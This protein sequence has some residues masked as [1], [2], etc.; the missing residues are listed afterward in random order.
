MRVRIAV[1]ALWGLLLGGQG[2]LAQHQDGVFSDYDSLV[3]TM[4]E[5][6]KERRISDLMLAF[7]GSDEMTEVELQQLEARVRSIFPQ[8][9]VHRER[10]RVQMLENN[11]RQELWAFY[12][13]SGYLYTYLV[14][15]DRKDRT[16][17]LSFKF[18]TDFNT[19]NG[20]F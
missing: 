14:I 1:L 20:L 15:H 13:G 3:A 8:D 16:L 11:F 2:A 9:F 5:L 18:N 19:L 6:V 17:S 4:D 10:V 12:T 7:G